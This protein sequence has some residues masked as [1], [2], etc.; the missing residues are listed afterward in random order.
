M[1]REIIQSDRK[2]RRQR[3]PVDCQALAIGNLFFL[4]ASLAT[5]YNS[6][7]PFVARSAD[8][9]FVPELRQACLRTALPDLF[10]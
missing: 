7:V 6:R 10:P 3:E 4:E 1:K 2:L 5:P 9:L 8:Y